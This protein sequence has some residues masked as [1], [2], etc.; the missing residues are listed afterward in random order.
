MIPRELKMH[1]DD[2]DLS[3]GRSRVTLQFVL[4]RGTYATIFVKRLTDL[5][6]EL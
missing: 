1:A 2:D 5:A 6:T 3:S 4:P